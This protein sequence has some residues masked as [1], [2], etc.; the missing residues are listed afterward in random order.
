MNGGMES[1]WDTRITTI[2]GS[3]T[4]RNGG[5]NSLI[6][7]GTSREAALCPMAA[8]LSMQQTNSP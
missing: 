1:D 5:L 7:L 6:F 3:D 8:M 2:A 4:K